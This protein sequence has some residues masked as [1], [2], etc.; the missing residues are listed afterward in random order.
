MLL[1]KKNARTKNDALP[2]VS[3]KTLNNIDDVDNELL[4]SI[5]KGTLKKLVIAYDLDRTEKRHSP[6]L[7]ICQIT[8]RIDF[9][10]E[11]APGVTSID[12]LFEGC[13]LTSLPKTMDISRIRNVNRMFKDSFIVTPPL[14]LDLKK[15]EDLTGMF[16]KALIYAPLNINAPSAESMSEM[17]KMADIGEKITFSPETRPTDVHEMFAGARIHASTDLDLKKAENLTGMFK[18]AFIDVPLN[19]NAPSAKSMSEMFKMADIGEKITF[20][21][22][23]RPANVH[24]M[25]ENAKGYLPNVDD[26]PAMYRQKEYERREAELQK[27]RSF[28]K[29]AICALTIF[30]CPGP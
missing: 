11:F 12:S 27:H 8:D 3:Q 14:D 26:L 24:E 16:R 10:I 6:F 15:A 20:S 18:G 2:T 28:K 29:M 22:E 30:A 25:F 4:R 23:T 7:R 17:F 5:E 21:P 19:I 13:W 9:D 1:Y